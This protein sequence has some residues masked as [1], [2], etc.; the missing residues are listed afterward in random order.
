MPWRE[1]TEPVRMERVAV[2]APRELI[3]D[4]LVRLADA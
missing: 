2:V 1:A 4:V 3:R